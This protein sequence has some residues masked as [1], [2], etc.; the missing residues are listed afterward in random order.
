MSALLFVHLI[1][2]GNTPDMAAAIALGGL[3][4]AFFLAILAIG[5]IAALIVP[6]LAP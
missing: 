2:M 6:N 5:F 1:A 3:P 4:V